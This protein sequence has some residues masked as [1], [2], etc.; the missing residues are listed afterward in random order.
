MY[1]TLIR[2]HEVHNITE[3]QTIQ[4]VGDKLKRSEVRREEKRLKQIAASAQKHN[5]K[6][7]TRKRKRNEQEGP[8]IGAAGSE[9]PE[10]C[11]TETVCKQVCS[12]AG[13]EGPQK[14][15]RT[16]EGVPRE[17]ADIDATNANIN[18]TIIA[19]TP[20]SKVSTS[21]PSTSNE[22]RHFTPRAKE[23]ESKLSASSEIQKTVVVSRVPNEVRG[24]TSYL[25]FACLL[26]CAI[27]RMPNGS[28]GSNIPEDE[29]TVT[30][31][32]CCKKKK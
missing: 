9:E 5:E 11:L 8:E 3:L 12:P 24:H 26:P 16:T 10:A 30:A 27:A 20:P 2:P 14:K 13:F 7:E 15:A 25:T 6:E 32:E 21:A 29:A 17:S 4:S 19:D 22:G 18:S 31:D 23:K 1:E 28:N